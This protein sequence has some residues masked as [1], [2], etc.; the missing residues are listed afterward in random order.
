MN[1][2]GTS[3]MWAVLA[4]TV[5][6]QA[7]KQG[8]LRWRGASA[9]LPP[10]LLLWLPVMVWFYQGLAHWSVNPEQLKM[11]E[12]LLWVAMAMDALASLIRVTTP[13]PVLWSVRLSFPLLVALILFQPRLGTG[14]TTACVVPV[15]GPAM[16]WS[17]ALVGP[18]TWYLLELPETDKMRGRAVYGD[19]HEG[20]SV[21]SP[22]SGRVDRVTDTGFIEITSEKG[23]LR[24]RIGP[25]MPDMMMAK[26]GGEVFANQPLGLM[27]E[28]EGTPG[29]RL[30]ILEGGPLVFA[31]CLAG[32]Y[33]AAQY[34]RVPAKRN[35]RVQSKAKSRFSF[36]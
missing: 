20:K 4:G 17:D 30:E 7:S 24:L 12:A 33:F 1:T 3:L 28:T 19:P 8:V 26:E 2:D 36:R 31:D 14:E 22:F 35:L 15:Y 6:L 27:G 5:L 25:L 16:V 34:E 11:G 29:V 18:T 13:S 23:D 32:R 9:W 10:T 21:F